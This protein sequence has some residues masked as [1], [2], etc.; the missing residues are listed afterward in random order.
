[1]ADGKLDGVRVAFLVTDG[2]EQVNREMIALF[3]RHAV[4]A[5]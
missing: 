2:F 1:M 3:A 5:G 4:A